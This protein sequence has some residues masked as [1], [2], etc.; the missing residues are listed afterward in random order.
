MNQHIFSIVDLIVATFYFVLIFFIAQSIR[1]KHIEQDPSYRYFV[2]GLMVKLIGGTVLCLTYVFYYGGGDTV[3]YH[4]DCIAVSK[5]FV[6][7]PWQAIRFTFLPLDAEMWYSLDADTGWIIYSY[8]DKAIWV[9]KLN[10]PLA[11]V[12]LNSFIG[13]TMLLSFFC[14]F[15]IWRMF[16][17]F[18][19]EFPELERQMALAFLFMPSV[20]FWGS[21]LLKDSITFAMVALYTTS[22]YHLLKIR[23]KV[24]LNIFLLIAASFLLIKIKPYIFFAV[25]P[26]SILWLVGFRLSK[27]ENRLVRSSIAPL[28]ILIS[29]FS[30]YM[31]LRVMGETLGEYS[32]SRVFEKAYVTNLDLKQDYYQGA[33][34]DIGDFEPTIPGMLGKAPAAINAALFRPYLWESYS[35]GMI[36]SGLENFVLLIVTIYLVLKMR[37]YNLFLLM[38]R[39]HILFFSVFF[40]IFFAFSVGLTTSNFGSLVRYK[41][42][43]IPFF[44]ASLFIIHYTFEKL[45]QE[46]EAAEAGQGSFA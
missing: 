21:G 14:Y 20:V 9:D 39:H 2:P 12:S 42:P 25:L 6:K 44:V 31:M 23:K 32:V 4:L 45:L 41:I 34:F 13:Q 40:S 7:N 10:W 8:D 19:R 17:M 15:A 3:N 24:L 36:M 43:A 26:G 5:L 38:F 22:Y 30:G 16:K 37:V 29:A 27:V 11:F 28:L 35:L 1:A 33:A 18:I 46:R